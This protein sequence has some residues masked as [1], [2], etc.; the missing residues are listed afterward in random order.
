[1]VEMESSNA[2][3][4]KLGMRS[5][6]QRRSQGM[7]TSL[8]RERVGQDAMRRAETREKVKSTDSKSKS[9]IR[10]KGDDG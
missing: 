10:K 6:L 5:R 3:W 1:M 9:K 4:F 2:Q 7:G 8:A